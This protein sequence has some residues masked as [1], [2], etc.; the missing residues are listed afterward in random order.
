MTRDHI[1]ILVVDDVPNNVK[2]LLSILKEEGLSLSF[3]LSGNDAIELA[4]K[5]SF[6]LI[7]LDILMPAKQY[8]K[9]I[10]TRIRPLSSF[11]LELMS[12]QYQEDLRLAAWIIL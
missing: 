1:K 11:L 2:M 5:E 6:A 10:R 3:A 4:K 8:I 12:N 9:L 7:L